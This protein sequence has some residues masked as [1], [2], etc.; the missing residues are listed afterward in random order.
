MTSS[1]AG[2]SWM[3]AGA[4]GRGPSPR[5]A[6]TRTLGATV[7]D[8]PSVVNVARKRIGDADL[9]ARVD[10]QVGDV[11]Q[12]PL[13]GGHD[14]FLLANIVHYWSPVRNRQ[15]LKLVRSS[16]QTGA[17]LLVADFW[18]NAT[19][20]EPLMAALFGCSVHSRTTSFALRLNTSDGADWN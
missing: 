1:S 10:F 2:D 17:R 19:H 11:F 15:L 9:S 8:L 5:P 7:F 6:G 14:V 16:A 13:P 4:P 20:T 18:T 3:W 12:D